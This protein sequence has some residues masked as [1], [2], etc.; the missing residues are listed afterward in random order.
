MATTGSNHDNKFTDYAA[1]NNIACEI[2]A[3][4]TAMIPLFQEM[5]L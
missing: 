1:A 5:F 2:A 4:S 3:N